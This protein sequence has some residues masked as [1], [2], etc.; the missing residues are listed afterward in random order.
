MFAA[1][2]QAFVVCILEPNRSEIAACIA[3]AVA[4]AHAVI[5]IRRMTGL[6]WRWLIIIGIALL[7]SITIPYASLYLAPRAR[8]LNTATRGDIPSLEDQLA[9]DRTLLNARGRGDWTALHHAARNNQ[10]AAVNFLVGKGADMN[11]QAMGET[12]FGI[13]ACH[14]YP[15]CARVMLEAGV[16]VNQRSM[17]HRST[18]LHIASA[19]GHSEVVKLLLEHG[20]DP[21]LEDEF[22]SPIRDAKTEE[23]RRLLRAHGAL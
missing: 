13:T 10:V 20:A 18:A 23:I 9:R 4:F 7:L 16:D 8:F 6:A 14:G 22:S 5:A 17:R 3:I 2:S 19:Q 12:P 21:N 1:A 11:A 15:E